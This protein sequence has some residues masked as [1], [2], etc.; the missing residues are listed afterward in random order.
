MARK[1]DNIYLRN[2]GKWEGRYVKGRAPD[3]RLRYGYVSG[4]TYEETRK[5]RDEA[6]TAYEKKKKET[7]AF[8]DDRF[9]FSVISMEWL[10][11]REIFLKESSIAKYR[12]ILNRYLIP[13]FGDKNITEITKED[14][15]QHIT[16][17][18]TAGGTLGNGLSSKMIRSV[19]SVFKAVAEYAGNTRDIR[20]V[21]FGRFPLKEQ[22][23]PLRVFSVKEQH[24]LEDCLL[25]DMRCDRLGIMLCLYTGI[26]LGELCALKWGDI[27]FDNKKLHIHATMTR[28]QIQG[29][30]NRRT[31]VITTPPKSACSIREIPLPS[32]LIHMLEE[33]E[34]P[35]DTYVL[36]GSRDVYVEP[37]TMENR[38]KTIVK[39]CGIT[40]AN[41]HALRHTFATRCIELG[42]DA[43]SLSEILGHS[44]VKITM[45]RYVHPTMDLKQKNMDKL[46]ALLMKKADFKL[47]D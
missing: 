44:S 26:R 7:E 28:I 40:D 22:K 11:N 3:G 27:S 15:S 42:F 35:E 8:S 39:M 31:K 6:A 1:G 10:K 13:Q 37:R 18:L 34:R 14:V 4:I 25:A 5:K 21:T 23:K 45:D 12:N 2:T 17:L 24:Q 36:T 19:V 38:F 9:L 32:D 33:M 30:P 41:F 16:W 43:K 20:V 46:S 29:D 47:T